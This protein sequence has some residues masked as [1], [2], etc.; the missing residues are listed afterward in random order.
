LQQRADDH[1]PGSNSPACDQTLGNIGIVPGELFDDP[2]VAGTKEEH[3]AIHGLVERAAEQEVATR[4][5]GLRQ[6]QVVL[7]QCGAP[8]DVVR[9]DVV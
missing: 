8:R 3:G 9:D 5:G 1:V 6:A 2:R 4:N 7:A